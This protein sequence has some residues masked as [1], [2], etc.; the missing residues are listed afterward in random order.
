MP[1]GFSNR[2]CN[3]PPPAAD[4]ERRLPPLP[5]VDAPRSDLLTV[6][7]LVLLPGLFRTAP[8][9]TA[10][11]ATLGITAVKVTALVAVI[12]LAGN[13]ARVRRAV[14]RLDGPR[15]VSRRDRCRAAVVVRHTTRCPE[16]VPLIFSFATSSDTIASN[17]D[18]IIRSDPGLWTLS[19]NK[20]RKAS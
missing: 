5:I 1:G 3:G 15:C 6:V 19:R 16:S 20:E 7:V 18:E 8:S 13:R 9:T 11:A 17:R 2:A 14:R 4:A 10:L 12:V